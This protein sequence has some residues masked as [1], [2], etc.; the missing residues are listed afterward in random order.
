MSKKLKIRVLRNLA[1]PYS[2]YKEGQVVDCDED[3][4]QELLAANLA[5]VPHDVDV[6]APRAAHE[7]GDDLDAKTIVELHELAKAEAINLHGFARRGR[8]DVG[9]R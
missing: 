5:E 6:P 9:E 8:S 3:E 2:A 4:A 1:K 7:T